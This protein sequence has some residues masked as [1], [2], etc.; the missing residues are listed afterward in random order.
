MSEEILSGYCRSLDAARKVFIEEGE[1]DCDYAVCPYAAS[2]PIGRE[3]QKQ[4]NKQ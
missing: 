1:P 2:C 3:I 4:E